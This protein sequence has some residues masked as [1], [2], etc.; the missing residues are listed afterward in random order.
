MGWGRNL[1]RR[2]LV[3]EVGGLVDRRRVERLVDRLVNVGHPV[4][5][6]MSI[7]QFKANM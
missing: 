5:E 4:L 2:G 6:H 3:G 7:T 1:G